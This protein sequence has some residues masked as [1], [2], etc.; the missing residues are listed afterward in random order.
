MCPE[1][2]GGAHIEN[3]GGLQLP[4]PS[5]APWNQGAPLNAQVWV[6]QSTIILLQTA[7]PPNAD[8]FE[9]VLTSEVYWSDL[10]FTCESH[11]S[12]GLTSSHASCFWS[13]LLPEALYI[14]P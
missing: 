5:Y 8:T 9:S 11:H 14:A 10:T 4:P 3:M 12:Y 13:P 1:N 6:P 2:M 7:E